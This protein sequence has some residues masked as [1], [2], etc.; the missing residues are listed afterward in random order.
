MG[1]LN[2]L[3]PRRLALVEMVKLS[4]SIYKPKNLALNI[5]LGLTL[6]ARNKNKNKMT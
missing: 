3:V 1:P 2:M 5:A 4:F 6:L